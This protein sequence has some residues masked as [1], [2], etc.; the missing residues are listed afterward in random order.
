[1]LYV[2]TFIVVVVAVGLSSTIHRQCR[3][4]RHRYVLMLVIIV[5]IQLSASTI[6]TLWWQLL[7]KRVVIFTV[8][9]LDTLEEE[10]GLVPVM[11]ALLEGMGRAAMVVVGLERIF[12]HTRFRI[13]N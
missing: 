5:R 13:I 11:E 9:V 10:D 7:D 6:G 4:R 2:V 1:M 12:I 8:V 3:T